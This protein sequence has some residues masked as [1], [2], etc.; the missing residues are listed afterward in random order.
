[1]Q[2]L[3]GWIDA[4]GVSVSK[5]L[6]S[7]WPAVA[8]QVGSILSTLLVAMV[9]LGMLVAV[10]STTHLWP[11]PSPVFVWSWLGIVLLPTALGVLVRQAMKMAAIN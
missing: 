4:I 7:F 3:G 9:V 1:M 5:I 6:R 10:G 2:W 11:W 8:D